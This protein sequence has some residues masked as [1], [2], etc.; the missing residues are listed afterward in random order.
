MAQ[1]TACGRKRFL[2]LIWFWLFCRRQGE[3]AGPPL[4]ALPQTRLFPAPAAAAEEA[5]EEEEEEEEEEADPSARLAPRPGRAG[6]DPR[7]PPA[8]SAALR[9]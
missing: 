7:R 5:E 3:E 2:V 9:P 6:R 1:G 8:A 4:T